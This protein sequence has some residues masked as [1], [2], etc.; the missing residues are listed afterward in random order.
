VC[1]DR[2]AGTPPELQPRQWCLLRGQV[3]FCVEPTK[4]PSDYSLSYASCQTGVTLYHVEHVVIAD[5]TVQGFQ[6]DGINLFN[7]ARRVSL[8]NVTCRGNGRAGLT[9]SGASLAEIEGSLLGDNGE[10]QLL[11]LPYS[12][13]HVRNTYLLGNTAPGWVDRAGRVYLGDTRME[14]GLNQFPPAAAE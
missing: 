14:G 6:L 3:Y 1:A 9:V 4:L 8:V 11:T 10:A 2:Q 7:S 12:E 5:L 13:T